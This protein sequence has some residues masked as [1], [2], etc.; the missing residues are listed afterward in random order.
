MRHV[1]AESRNPV[2]QVDHNT[3]KSMESENDTRKQGIEQE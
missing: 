1:E 2:L 3:F